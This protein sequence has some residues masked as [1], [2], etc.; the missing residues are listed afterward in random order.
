MAIKR[1]RWIFVACALLGLHA[2]AP[3][4]DWTPR[5]TP[6]DDL[7]AVALH[8]ALVDPKD[9]GDLS[10]VVATTEIIVRSDI[11]DSSVRIGEHALPSIQ[12][13]TVRL[14]ST[15]QLRV[16]AA[17]EGDLYVLAVSELTLVDDDHAEFYIGTEMVTWPT[18]PVLCCCSNKVRYERVDGAWVYRGA[19]EFSCA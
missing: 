8:R 3:C 15:E 9:L 4:G 18:R 10:L 2:G 12:G 11:P 7:F 19:T 14:L 1:A 16:R 6:L 5:S 13:K 17:R